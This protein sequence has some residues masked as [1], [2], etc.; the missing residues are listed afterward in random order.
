MIK[1]RG[2]KLVLTGFQLRFVHRNH[3]SLLLSLH[4]ISS[5]VAFAIV[6]F[7]RSFRS[8]QRISGNASHLMLNLLRLQR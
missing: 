8:T 4:L 2:R 7:S 1:K 5:P 6:D 3:K